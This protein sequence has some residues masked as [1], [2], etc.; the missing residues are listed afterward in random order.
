M[1]SGLNDLENFEK[2][3]NLV[4]FEILFMAIARLFIAFEAQL[5]P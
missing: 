3:P 2:F 1:I 4:T 5:S